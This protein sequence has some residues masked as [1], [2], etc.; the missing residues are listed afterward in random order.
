MSNS[1][2]IAST[3]ISSLRGLFQKALD[4]EPTLDEL[5]SMLEEMAD[6]TK[7]LDRWVARLDIMD[8]IIKEEEMRIDC[9]HCGNPITQY[10]SDNRSGYPRG[11]WYHVPSNNKRCPPTQDAT[12]PPTSPTPNQSALGRRFER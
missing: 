12:P 3:H 1:Y 11:T 5:V 4:R 8:R 2:R 7:P 6:A 9:I 10:G